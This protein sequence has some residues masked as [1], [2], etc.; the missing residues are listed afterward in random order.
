M[1]LALKRSLR[2]RIVGNLLLLT[3]AK[4]PHIGMR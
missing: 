3:V 1:R 4:S 2:K